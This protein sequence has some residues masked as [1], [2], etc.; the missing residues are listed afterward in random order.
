MTS[1]KHE[2]ILLSLSKIKMSARGY[3]R[4][5]GEREDEEE[6]VRRVGGRGQNLVQAVLR[7]RRERAGRTLPNWLETWNN[8]LRPEW[9]VV[10][11][12]QGEE[13]RPGRLQARGMRLGTIDDGPW[14][15]DMHDNRET[16]QPRHRIRWARTRPSTPSHPDNLM[17]HI[18]L[19]WGTL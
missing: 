8:V 1:S 2:C 10:P 13:R 18:L 3:S 5:S 11:H 19:L 15:D 4:Y 7:V 12:G 16:D 6:L 14:T 17:M 9:E